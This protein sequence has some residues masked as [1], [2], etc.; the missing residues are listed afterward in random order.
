MGRR[1]TQARRLPRAL[2]EHDPVVTD[3]LCRLPTGRVPGR[4]RLQESGPTPVATA[5]DPYRIVLEQVLQL[6]DKE[7]E[8]LVGHLLTALG[9]EGSEIT[10]KTGDGGVDAIGDST[11]RA[12]PR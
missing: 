3:G 1:D 12:S 6:D 2:P 4:D 8:I 5:Y 10:G 7:F 9:F 11:W